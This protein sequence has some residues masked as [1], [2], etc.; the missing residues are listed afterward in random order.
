MGGVFW[1]CD[2]SWGVV[3][4]GNLGGEVFCW[5]YVVPDDLLLSGERTPGTPTLSPGLSVLV[6]IS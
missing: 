2:L 6:S 3:V 4:S 1:W 5:W